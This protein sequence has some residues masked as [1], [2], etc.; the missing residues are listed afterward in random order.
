MKK[1]VVFMLATCMFVSSSYAHSVNFI[2]S[3]QSVY[4]YGS[5]NNCDGDVCPL[6]PDNNNDDCDSGTCPLPDNG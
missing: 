3:S 4:V 6:P 1:L 5:D 2:T